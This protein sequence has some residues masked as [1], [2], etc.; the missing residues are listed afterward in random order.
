MMQIKYILLSFVMMNVFIN[1][2]S[3]TLK[4][5]NVYPTNLEEN[6][7]FESFDAKTNTIKGIYFMVLS[8]GDNSEFI[9]PEFTVKL[10]LYQ[11]GK[12]PIYIKTF[13]EKGINH[14]GKK[15]YDKLNIKIN[16]EGI[17]PGTYRIGIHVNADDSFKENTSDN[18]IL[19]KQGII[20]GLA[21]ETTSSE[22][23]KETTE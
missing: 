4:A 18:A 20:I 8:D 12:D 7:Y 16:T 13:E 10:Y 15:E 17:E 3:Q 5:C 23:E 2:N 6:M 11:S 14:F 22:T 9:T 1:A 19:F 21:S